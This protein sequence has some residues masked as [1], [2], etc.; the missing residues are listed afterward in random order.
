MIQRTDYI[1]VMYIKQYIGVVLVIDII[2]VY[3]DNNRQSAQLKH[4]DVVGFTVRGLGY[5]E[6]GRI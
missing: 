2:A 3:G 4:L 1:F 6:V 5:I